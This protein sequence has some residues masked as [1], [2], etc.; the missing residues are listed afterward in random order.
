[1]KPYESPSIEV[2]VFLYEDAIC[3]SVRPQGSWYQ[4]IN[5]DDPFGNNHE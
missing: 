5:W 4:N 1:M 3:N 2:I